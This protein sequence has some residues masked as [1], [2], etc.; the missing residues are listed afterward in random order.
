MALFKRFI[1]IL[2]S[3][4]FTCFVYGQGPK[5]KYYQEIDYKP[6][7]FG[8]TLGLNTMDFAVY[9]NAENHLQDSLTAD[10]T[11][12]KPGF[13]VN[14]VS[15]YLFHKNFNVRFLPGIIFGERELAWYKNGKIMDTM[16]IESNLLDFPILIKYKANRI[17]NYRPYLIGGA[18]VRVDMAARKEYDKD[19]DV[20]VRLKRLDYYGEIGFGIDFYLQYFKFSTELKLSVGMRNMMVQKPSIKEPQYANAIDR[21]NSSLILFSMHFE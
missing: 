2:I 15:S 3:Y 4:L 5:V 6:I 12:L 8:F 19:N 10:V 7:H 20:Y 21:L 11:V 17:D 9:H 14:I 13:H 18:N 1:I 16:K